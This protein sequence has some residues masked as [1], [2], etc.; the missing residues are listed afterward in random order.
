VGCQPLAVRG[1][2][3]TGAFYIGGLLRALRDSRFDQMAAALSGRTV[4]VIGGGSVAMDC[5]AS[6]VRLGARDV[7]LIYRRSFAQMPPKKKNASRPCDPVFITCCSTSLSG[8]S[9]MPMAASPA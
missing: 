4:A 3:D 6:A 5:A 1:Y 9:A 8:S 2:N 7:Y